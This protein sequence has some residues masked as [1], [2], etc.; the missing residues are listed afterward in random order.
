MLVHVFIVS[1]MEERWK[2]S[3]IL[4]HVFAY[5]GT[6]ECRRI[7][8]KLHTSTA[9]MYSRTLHLYIH[10][11]MKMYWRCLYMYSL[12]ARWKKGGMWVPSWTTFSHILGR[13]NVDGF[14]S[15]YIQAPHECILGRCICIFINGMKMYW[16]CLYMYSLWARWKK[17]GKWVPSWTISSDWFENVVQIY[18]CILQSILN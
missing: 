7:S 4:D 12:W 2:V 11:G 3:S 10:H 9:W 16:R 15:N 17:G 5:F 6:M 13:W 1:K 14:R 8:I 18:S